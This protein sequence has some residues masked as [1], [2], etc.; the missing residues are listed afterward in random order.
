[1]CQAPVIF[2]EAIKEDDRD[3]K[4]CFSANGFLADHQAF[5]S[6]DF[7]GADVVHRVHHL[8]NRLICMGMIRAVILPELGEVLVT[9]S[10]FKNNRSHPRT[11]RRPMKK[12]SIC[13]ICEH[14][15]K[16]CNP[17]MAGLLG[18]RYIFE[19]ACNC[20]SDRQVGL[21]EADI[22]GIIGLYLLT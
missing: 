10:H 20:C 21:M 6:C 22:H 14:F 5:G 18:V 3:G 1:V 12:R 19:I 13:A 17:A 8:H 11:R 7:L 9:T 4:E 16:A 2:L 15:E